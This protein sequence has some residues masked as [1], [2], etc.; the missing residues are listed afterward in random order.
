ME[1]YAQ[2]LNYAIPSFLILIAIEYGYSYWKEVSVNRLYDTISS[3]SS[4]ITNV[5]KDVLGLSIAIITYS[6]MVDHWSIIQIPAT[7]AIYLVAFIGLDFAGYWSHRFSHVI[8]VFWNRHI[9]H[10]SSEEFNLSCALRQSV[11]EIFAIFTILY[12]PMAL[13]GI[14]AKVVGTV[15]PLHLFLQFWYHTR[16]IQKMGWLEYVIVTPSH[17]RVHHAVNPEYMDRNYGQ[18]FIIWDKL[19]GTFQ[20]ELDHVSAV[21]GVTRPVNTWN[22]WKINYQH[23]WL[24]IKDAWRTK[25]WIDKIK[26]WWMP[27]GWRPQDVASLYPLEYD[28]DIYHRSKYHTM[29]SGYLDVLSISQLLITLGIMMYLFN[30]IATIGHKELFLYGCLIFISVYAYTA[31]MDG[32][33]GAFMAECLKFGLAVYLF[34]GWGWRWYQLDSIWSFILVLYFL[35]SLSMTFYFTFFSRATRHS[36]VM[37]SA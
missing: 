17:H 23:I 8:N 19:F 24:L 29:G 4:G 27:T 5:V 14:P 34:Y 22:P 7:W 16:L 12:L 1:A 10:H 11:S 28:K 18:I 2:V 32:D 15:G 21:Y 36:F 6:Y 25:S 31:V 20:K 13:L 35:L 37:A 33:K 30:N 26:V 9:I 3:L